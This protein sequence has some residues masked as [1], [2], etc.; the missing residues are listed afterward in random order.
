MTITAIPLLGFGSKTQWRL[1]EGSGPLNGHASVYIPPTHLKTVLKEY[2]IEYLELMIREAERQDRASDYMPL[3]HG[4]YYD[5]SHAYIHMEKLSMTVLSKIEEEGIQFVYQ[6]KDKFHNLW[7]TSTIYD[8]YSMCRAD[9][10]M[11]TDSGDLKF[12][13]AG[14]AQFQKAGLSKIQ[15]ANM[16]Y[17]FTKSALGAHLKYIANKQGI[18]LSEMGRLYSDCGKRFDVDS[19]GD[20]YV[21]KE[22]F[23]MH[24]AKSMVEWF[25]KYE[26]IYQKLNDALQDEWRKII[27]AFKL[28]EREESQD[29]DSRILLQTTHVEDGEMYIKII[30]NI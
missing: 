13:D 7:N 18:D 4:V 14:R 16:C 8:G 10:M 28:E 29:Y 3:V 6:N 15:R 23:T 21:K 20:K 30:F 12:I 24:F 5:D 27:S 9:N 11:L 25:D 17:V 19:C 22:Q 26:T 1:I 2:P